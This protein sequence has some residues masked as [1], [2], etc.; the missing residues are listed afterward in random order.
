MWCNLHCVVIFGYVINCVITHGYVILS[1]CFL[2][3]ACSSF[4]R[5]FILLMCDRRVVRSSRNPVA[6]ARQDT[7]PQHYT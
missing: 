6:S 2:Y 4:I 5:S 3:Y 1:V 7:V